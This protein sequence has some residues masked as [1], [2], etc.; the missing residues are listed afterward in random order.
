[1]KRIFLYSRT[2]SCA[3]DSYRGQKRTVEIEETKISIRI[4]RCE[5]ILAAWN[6]CSIERASPSLVRLT[7]GEEGHVRAFKTEQFRT[8]GEYTS[9]NGICLTGFAKR[10]WMFFCAGRWNGEEKY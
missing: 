8:G 7:A 10:N 9:G 5:S 6:D 4:N 3:E 2:L 1:M